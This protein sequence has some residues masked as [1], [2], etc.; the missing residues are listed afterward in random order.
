VTTMKIE[1]VLGQLKQHMTIILVT[2]LTQQA[3]RMADHTAFFNASQLV[4]WGS[5]EQ[6]FTAPK[7]EITGRYLNGEFG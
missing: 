2:N 1:E 5:T 3:R 4:E 7:K 6:M